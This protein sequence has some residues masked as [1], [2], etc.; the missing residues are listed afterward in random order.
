MYKCSDAVDHVLEHVGRVITHVEFRADK[1]QQRWPVQ[2]NADKCQQ[3]WPVQ[4]NLT[5][6]YILLVQKISKTVRGGSKY[7]T[8]II[9]CH[10][11]EWQ[12]VR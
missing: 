12:I 1:C 10:K 11:F 5:F 6:Y 3:R 9:R 8:P 2:K 7:G 4:K